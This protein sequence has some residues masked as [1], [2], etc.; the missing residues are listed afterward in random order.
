MAAVAL[1][2]LCANGLAA[3]SASA[4]TFCVAD[5]G[6]VGTSQP[7]LQSALTMAQTSMGDDRVQ[8]G[9]GTFQAAGPGGFTYSAAAGNTVQLV[10]AG[11]G[12]TTLTAP[13][14]TSSTSITTL[15]LGTATGS[16]STISDLAV[17]LS[18]ITS[19]SGQ[20]LGIVARGADMNRVA[21]SSPPTVNGGSMG[22]FFQTGT[23]QHSTVSVPQGI[24]GVAAVRVF[25][26]GSGTIADST[27]SGYFGIYGDASTTQT[28][29]TAQRD[30]IDASGGNA[31]IYTRGTSLTAE[32]VLIQV[33]A[34]GTGVHAFCN[35]SVDGTSTLRNI[36]IAGDPTYGLYDEC[37]N[38][39]RTA[40]INLDSSIIDT[41]FFSVFRDGNGPSGGTVNVT[42]TYSNYPDFTGSILG[43]AGS[44]NQ[45]STDTHQDP[46]FVDSAGGDFHLLSDSP[47][48][49]I[50]NP[51]N[52]GGPTDLD[53]LQRV[54]NGRLDMGA[55]EFQPPPPPT[56]GGGPPPATAAA[57]TGQRAAALKKCKKK[58]S[59]KARKK[60]KKRAKKLPV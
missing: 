7:N 18:A 41:E 34:G 22:V 16:G 29:I 33:T 57:S 26:G 8:V 32:D 37:A 21:V 17:H 56:G 45:D 40:T 5:P 13:D 58:K 43:S 1:G 25:E 39:G 28:T 48:R 44:L 11:S 20:S 24:G 46:G 60:C 23:L 2:L 38:S 50:G 15:D 14:I 47:L 42:A 12:Q 54:T 55:F 30:R 59:A 6:C 9:P 10:G 36:T 4:V 52:S 19:G 53:G 3:S 51:V 35:A 49:D 27:V 31:G